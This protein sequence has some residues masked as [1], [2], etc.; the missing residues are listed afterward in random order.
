MVFIFVFFNFLFYRIM[1]AALFDTP[2]TIWATALTSI[3]ITLFLAFSGPVSILLSYEERDGRD[4]LRVEKLFCVF[5]AVCA[6]SCLAAYLIALGFS[7]RLYDD[8]SYWRRY[9]DFWEQDLF[10]FCVMI[11]IPVVVHLTLLLRQLRR[12]DFE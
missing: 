11:S 10:W 3:V 6:V 2:L 8:I 5:V 9:R 1:S 12:T 7:Q 4:R